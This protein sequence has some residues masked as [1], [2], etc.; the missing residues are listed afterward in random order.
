MLFPP[1]PDIQVYREE[2]AAA[3]AR[4]AVLAPGSGVTVPK[5]PETAMDKL[6]LKKTKQW[7]FKNTKFIRDMKELK[8]KTRW[9]M[10]KLDPKQINLQGLEGE[11]LELAQEIWVENN[12]HLVRKGINEMR[13][14][15]QQET[16]KIYCNN[17]LPSMEE[18]DKWPKVD[19]IVSLMKCENLLEDEDVPAKELKSNQDRFD[20]LVD[21]LVPKAAGNH[22]FPPTIRHVYPMLE[23]MT[24]Q[25]ANM[26]PVPSVSRS[27]MAFLAVTYLNYYDGW[28]WDHKKKNGLLKTVGGA[29]CFIDAKGKMVYHEPKPTTPYTSADKG[30]AP[31]GGWN[32]P[33]RKKFKELKAEFKALLEDPNARARILQ[34][35]EECL[36][37]LR[38]LHKVLEAEAKWATRGRRQPNRM[39]KEEDSGEDTDGDE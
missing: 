15:I 3:R 4:N 17:I 11:A 36:A 5:T 6:V 33:G 32:A 29:M 35:D 27:D 24:H 20:N 2:L 30:C 14:Y 19:Q 8:E 7:L 12:A 25:D 16:K 37:R 9:L 39:A 10:G 13:N 22:A 1:V 18:Q 34:A 21:C 31:F 26:E 23:A 38:A 28:V